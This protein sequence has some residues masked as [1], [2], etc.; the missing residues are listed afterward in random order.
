LIVM[1]FQTAYRNF[2]AARTTEQNAIGAGNHDTAMEAWRVALDNLL[3]APVESPRDVAQL[4]DTMWNMTAPD[5]D[6]EDA[7][8][9]T[10]AW[11]LLDRV[12]VVLHALAAKPRDSVGRMGR[13]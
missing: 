6:T 12:R 13:A 7:V 4:F 5:D 8:Q 3:T 2:D 11:E 1:D 10:G 9:H